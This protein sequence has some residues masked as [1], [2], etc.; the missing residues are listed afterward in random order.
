MFLLE[1]A[2]LHP[3]QACIPL[4]EAREGSNVEMANPVVRCRWADWHPQ[5]AHWKRF[6]CLSLSLPPRHVN[7][8]A[9]NT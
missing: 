4:D 9:I 3:R 7:V 1:A 6:K 2:E 5:V 8:R